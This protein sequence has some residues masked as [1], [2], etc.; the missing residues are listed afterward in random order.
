M[1]THRLLEHNHLITTFTID[2]IRHYQGG[3]H[4]HGKKWLPIK[5]I[6]QRKSVMINVWSQDYKAVLDLKP[7]F[8]SFIIACKQNLKYN[9][10][11]FPYI[12][13]T[14]VFQVSIYD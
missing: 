7:N 3:Q 2:P 1:A 10:W 9:S 14:L 11:L 5:Y 8:Q 4:H 12:L 13:S 6:V